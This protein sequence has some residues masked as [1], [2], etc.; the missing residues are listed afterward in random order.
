MGASPDRVKPKTIKLLFV[1]SNMFNQRPKVSGL[2]IK[3]PS[4]IKILYIRKY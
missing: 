3:Y 1:A 2:N 4:M